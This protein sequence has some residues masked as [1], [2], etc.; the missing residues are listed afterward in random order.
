MSR[1][2]SIGKI[3]EVAMI[4]LAIKKLHLISQSTLHQA[5]C[6]KDRKQLK[7]A[8]PLPTTHTLQELQIP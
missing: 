8:C 2:E 3:S 5:S 6:F 1:I 4:L 7:V